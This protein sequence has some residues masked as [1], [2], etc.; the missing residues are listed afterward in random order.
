M[1]EYLNFNGEEVSSSP[2][3][4]LAHIP[5]KAIA[6]LDPTAKFKF[7]PIFPAINIMV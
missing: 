2:H 6:I 1:H 7:L 4:F 5:E 3:P